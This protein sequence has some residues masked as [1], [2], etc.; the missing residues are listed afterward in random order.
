MYASPWS[1]PAFMKTNNNMLQEVSYFLNFVSLGQIIML[2]SLQI[3]KRRYPIWG[4]TIQ[5]EPWFS[6]GNHV[7]IPQK[8][9][10]I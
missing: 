2:S 4:L 7:S 9:N 5:N 10:V 3:M 1:P 8:K 6:P